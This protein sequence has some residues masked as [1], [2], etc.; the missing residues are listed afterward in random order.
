MT[1]DGFINQRF[2]SFIEFIFTFLHFSLFLH[3]ITIL[4]CYIWHNSQ[5][6]TSS[7]YLMKSVRRGMTPPTKQNERFLICN[8][9]GTSFWRRICTWKT[10]NHALWQKKVKIE[11]WYHVN[12]FI[13]MIVEAHEEIHY[14]YR[15]IKQTAKTN[16][17]WEHWVI[18]IH[19]EATQVSQALR[20]LHIK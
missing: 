19:N 3:Q 20:N 18:F 17:N 15:V 8:Q 16:Y 6:Y 13:S 2:E 7:N 5:S 14:I 9:T 10:F 12:I 1:L 11:Y 4:W